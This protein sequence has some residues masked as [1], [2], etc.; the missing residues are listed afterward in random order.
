VYEILI[1]NKLTGEQDLI[2]GYSFQDACRRAH[3]LEENYKCLD[4]EY[5]D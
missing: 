5:Y 4:I 1:E 3:I 2:Y